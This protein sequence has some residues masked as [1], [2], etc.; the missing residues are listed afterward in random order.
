M[1]FKLHLKQPAKL[2]S[3]SIQRKYFV[4]LEHN[5]HSSFHLQNKTDSISPPAF[6][7]AKLKLPPHVT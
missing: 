4:L 5:S 6:L 1:S 7:E 3:K 2:F